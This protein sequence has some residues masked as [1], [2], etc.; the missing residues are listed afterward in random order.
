MDMLKEMEKVFLHRLNN[1]II[2]EIWL[3][4]ANMKQVHSLKS[5]KEL[6]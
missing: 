2:G 3:Y 6:K 4:C 1:S 5:I